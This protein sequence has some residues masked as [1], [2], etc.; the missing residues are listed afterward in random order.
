MN[1]KLLSEDDGLSTCNYCEQPIY[2]HKASGYW[3]HSG[4]NILGCHSGYNQNQA[5]P[6]LPKEPKLPETFEQWYKE[7]YPVAYNGSYKT[8]EIARAAW[9]AGRGER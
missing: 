4:T 8:Y 3:F 2:W 9:N 5:S 7:F 1:S 6:K